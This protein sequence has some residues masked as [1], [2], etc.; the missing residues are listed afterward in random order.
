[1]Y[2]AETQAF[3]VDYLHDLRVAKWHY[4]HAARI[5]ILSIYLNVRVVEQEN[6]MWFNK[7]KLYS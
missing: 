1:M 7:E 2:S 5:S 6:Y 4:E 3:Q